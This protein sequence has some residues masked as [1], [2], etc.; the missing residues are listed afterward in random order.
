[1]DENERK[2]LVSTKRQSKCLI[3]GDPCDFSENQL[4]SYN[5]VL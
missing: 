3:F 5:A 4:P 2:G 1:M